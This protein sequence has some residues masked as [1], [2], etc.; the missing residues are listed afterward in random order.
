[1]HLATE[2]KPQIRR[3][4]LVRLPEVEALTGL[5]KSTLYLL[6][7]RGQFVPSVRV[8]ERCVAWPESKVLQWVQDRIAAS[9]TLGLADTGTLR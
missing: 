4:K 7:R 9:D 1:M 6:M 2:T 8:T 3:D 5:K